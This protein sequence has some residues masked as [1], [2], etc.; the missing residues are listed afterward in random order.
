LR[1]KHAPGPRS[2]SVAPPENLSSAA[3]ATKPW[4]SGAL[5][6]VALHTSMLSV[7][8]YERHEISSSA[9]VKGRAQR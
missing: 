9:C 4:H 8:R 1:K 3:T 5:S 2:L 6:Q 7:T